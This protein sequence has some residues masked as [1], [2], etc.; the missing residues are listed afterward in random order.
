MKV[1]GVEAKCGDCKF[2]A[3]SVCA[4][5]PPSA[6]YSTRTGVE[7]LWPPVEEDEWCGE[8]KPTAQAQHRASEEGK[9]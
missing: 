4:A 9:R 5:H 7:P 6:R 3:E 8:F 2:Y 1:Q